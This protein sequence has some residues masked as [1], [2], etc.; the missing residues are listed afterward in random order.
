MY[1]TTTAR[2][3]LHSMASAAAEFV[4]QGLDLYNRGEFEA[5]LGVLDEDVVA[6]VP[7]VMANSG[8]YHGPDGFRRM[9]DHW[10]EAWDEFRIE[11]DAIED[12][13]SDVV[14][15]TVTQHARGRGSGIEASMPAVHLMRVHNGRLVEW[16][17]SQTRAEALEH[18]RDG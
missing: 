2:V 18:V 11:I 3:I 13:D 7:D 15:A 17:I 6:V 10:Q 4:R 1:A 8:V 9:L 16:R 14:L 5:L 12:I